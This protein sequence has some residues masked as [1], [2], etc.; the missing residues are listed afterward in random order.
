[1]NKD[2][3][4]T[5]C[6]A[7]ILFQALL[8]LCRNCEEKHVLHLPEKDLSYQVNGFNTGGLV[9]AMAISSTASIG[10]IKR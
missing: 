4:Y 7:T 2:L 6:G 8:P 1:M 3:V 5:I 10:I 9:S